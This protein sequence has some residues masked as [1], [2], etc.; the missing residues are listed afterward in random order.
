[1]TLIKI[2]KRGEVPEDVKIVAQDESIDLGKLIGHIER[3]EVVIPKNRFR[4]DLHP[5]GIGKNL[6]TKVNAN[7][8]TSENFSLLEAELEK[9]DVAIKAGC[10]TVMDLST[11]GDLD[12]IR[13]AIIAHSTI[14]VGT[15]PI[16][17]AAIEA[18]ERR[19]SIVDMQI[20]DLFKV[21]ERQA[22]DGVDF[23]T[24]H[25]GVTR[26][27]IE[28]MKGQ[29]RVTDVVS[30]GGAFLVGWILHNDRENPL[31]TE[32]DRLLEIAEKYDLTLSLGD[33]MRP[34]SIA[35]ASD[36][37]Q[38]SELYTLGELVSRAREVGVQVI[39]EGPGHV[40]L[41][42]IEANVRL[43]KEICHGAPFYVLGPIVTD[44]APGYDEITSAIG[45]ALAAFYGADF[46]CY[47]TPREHLGLPTVQDVRRGVVASRIAAHAADIATG[48]PGAAEWDLKIAR[49]RKALDWSQQINLSIDPARARKAYQER[50]GTEHPSTSSGQENACTMCGKFCAMKLVAEYLGSS[51]VEKC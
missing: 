46:L 27:A 8:G 31:Y 22:R 43:E 7:I 35:D 12:K 5:L 36:R 2:V 26:R 19:G 50:G 42:Q 40:P 51:Q 38:F 45:G 33:G 20:D 37:A 48:T 3:G 15:V 4:I 11:A 21:I 39:V 24:V 44:I 13:R 25:C 30:R 28:A 41:N 23:I 34:G 47:V 10:D 14:P 16:Y 32:F 18:I 6:R 29:G 49:A 9:L 17:Q 1:M